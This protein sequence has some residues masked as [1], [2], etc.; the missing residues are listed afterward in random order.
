MKRN[1]PCRCGSGKKYKFCCLRK[2]EQQFQLHLMQERYQKMINSPCPM[3]DSKKKFK[4]CCLT[5]YLEQ[6]KNTKQVAAQAL[7]AET[8]LTS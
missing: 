6:K 5:K 4:D 1:G 8:E 7:L 3:C 2:D